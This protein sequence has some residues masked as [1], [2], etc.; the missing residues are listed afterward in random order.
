MPTWD[1]KCSQSSLLNW[2][3][4]PYNFDVLEKIRFPGTQK[5]YCIRLIVFLWVWILWVIDWV[6][7]MFSPARLA[8]KNIYWRKLNGHKPYWRYGHAVMLFDFE[9]RSS[10]LTHPLRSPVPWPME[11]WKA[12]WDRGLLHS[13]RL[14]D[15]KCYLCFQLKRF[16][17]C[18]YDNS[19]AVFFSRGDRAD[20][21]FPSS[22]ASEKIWSRCIGKMSKYS[23]RQCG[24]HRLYKVTLKLNL[25]TLKLCG[26]RQAQRRM[27]RRC[28]RGV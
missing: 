14:G 17:I 19:Y 11:I 8:M 9:F 23:N 21:H 6:P 15:A 12:A 25:A 20:R 28:R 4:F 27:G 26:R 22:T 3:E 7:P 18:C 24:T 10:A 16:E 13:S 5:R 1:G 2:R